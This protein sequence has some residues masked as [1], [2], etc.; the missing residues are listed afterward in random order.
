MGDRSKWTGR[1]LESETGLQYNRVRSY[2]ASTGRW[3]S[4]DPAGFEA[5][6]SNLY[7]YVTNMPTLATDPAGQDFLVVGSSVNYAWTGTLLTGMAAID[8][9]TTAFT[10]V[11]GSAV[12]ISTG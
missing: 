2:D 5:G 8:G 3:Q 7:R 9:T 10:Y 6:D 1:E 4:Q 11:P 12:T